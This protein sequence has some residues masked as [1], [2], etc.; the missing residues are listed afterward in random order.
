MTAQVQEMARLWETLSRKVLATVLVDH[1]ALFP[2]LDTLGPNAH[3]FTPKEQGIWAAVVQCSQENIPPTVEAVSLRCSAEP[4]YIQTVANQWNDDDGR[5]VLYHADELKRLGMLA[6]LRAI[7]R[8]MSDL[9]DPTALDTAIEYAAARLSGVM[10]HS[11]NRSGDAHAVGEAAWHELENNHQTEIP[12]GLKWFDDLAGGLWPGMNYWVA[13]A[14]K[15]GKTTLMRNIILNIAEQGVACDAFCAEGSREMFALDCQAM[16]ATRLLCQHGE[17]DQRKLRLSGLFLRRVWRNHDA[18]LTAQ[19][20]SAIKE[21]RETW[22]TL[23]IRVWDTVDGIRNLATLRHRVQQ[24]KFEFGSLVHWL[25]YSQ[26]FGS[27]GTLFDRQSKTAQVAQEI[28]QAEGVTMCILAQRNEAAIQ[29]GGDS[30]SVGV[31]GGGDASAAAD[32]LLVP[33][34]DHDADNLFHVKLKH[35]RHSGQGMGTHV[36]N[37]SSG[38][39]LDRWFSTEEKPLGF[40]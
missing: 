36:I 33:Q 7:G 23:N 11:T 37:R 29:G 21:A 20:L 30:Y 18:V 15:A 38:L 9:N 16:I 12:T 22:N 5:K 3:W 14:Y 39:M 10:A 35:S 34:V 13:G 2:L 28:A 25:D 6:D 31:K 40:Y 26:L 27:E 19:E 24:S 8:E 1:G 4:G 32:F 17:R